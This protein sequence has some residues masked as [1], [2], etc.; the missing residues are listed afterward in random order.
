MKPQS[1]M[2]RQVRAVAVI[3]AVL[4]VVSP[5]H[6]QLR[7]SSISRPSEGPSSRVGLLGGL[8]SSRDVN[9]IGARDI[10][11]VPQSLGGIPSFRDR[12]ISGGVGRQNFANP[13]FGTATR[14]PRS[15]TPRPTFLGDTGRANANE[16][17]YVT[18]YGQSMDFQNPFGGF[19]PYRTD[20]IPEMAYF[21]PPP[22]TDRYAAYF[23][24]VPPADATVATPPPA[25][26]DG[27]PGQISQDTSFSTFM[28][29]EQERTLDVMAERAKLAYQF[30][31]TP[32]RQDR[33]SQLAR[34]VGLLTNLRNLDRKSYLPSML[35]IHASMERGEAESM[36]FNIFTLVD[37]YPDVF[38]QP[39][40]I[41]QYFGDPA[42]YEAQ[43][44]R[45]LRFGDSGS[46][47]LRGYVVQAYA[48]WAL[49]DKP[50]VREALNK[51]DQLRMKQDPDPNVMKFYFAMGN[52]ALAD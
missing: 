28:E 8:F 41:Q 31:T 20:I 16:L 13:M 47:T 4:T 36:L 6:A 52:A 3:A 30:G 24:L 29:A 21:V 9:D 42:V 25:V 26:G 10:G 22:S 43:V 17:M 48:S 2:A 45:H 18:E 40:N 50:R 11:T 37:R 44:R 19:G 23:N 27:L 32:T 34:A 38:R 12:T 1:V 35:L 39:P 5:A 51:I 33:A 14:L 15:R 7:G 46:A 49:Q